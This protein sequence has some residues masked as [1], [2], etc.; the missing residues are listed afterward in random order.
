MS[1]IPNIKSCCQDHLELK[2]VTVY[3]SIH[4][5]HKYTLTTSKKKYFSGFTCISFEKFMFVHHL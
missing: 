3:I 5:L 2:Q 1:A 4:F